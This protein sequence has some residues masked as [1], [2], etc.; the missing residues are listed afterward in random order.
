VTITARDRKILLFVLGIGIVLAY[1][2]LLL[3]PKRAE[4]TKEQ[5]ALTAAQSARQTAAQRLAQLTAAKRSFAGDYQTVI[6]LGQS[7]PASLDMPSLLLQLNAAANGTGIVFNSVQ[8]GSR[9]SAPGSSSTSTPASAATKPAASSSGIPGLDSIPLTFT[10]TGDYFRLADFFH[11]MKRFVQV[12]N[13]QIAVHGRLITIDGFTF[14]TPQGQTA[15]PD[16]LTATVQ[17]T[18]YLAPKA[19]GLAAGATPQGPQA[20][21][22]NAASTQTAGSAPATPA[23]VITR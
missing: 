11:Q 21:T 23:A 17:A 20:P 19:Q 10:F 5:N 8:T 13:N 7:I 1:W 2:F 12:A 22:T 15:S 16:S 4:Q 3:S 18:V 6:R 9:S 14:K